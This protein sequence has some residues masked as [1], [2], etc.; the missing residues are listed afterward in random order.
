MTVNNNHNDGILFTAVSVPF[1][2]HKVNNNNQTIYFMTHSTQS[3]VTPRPFRN[4]DH[5][6]SFVLAE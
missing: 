6:V 3:V 5:M 2:C 4:L 1:V